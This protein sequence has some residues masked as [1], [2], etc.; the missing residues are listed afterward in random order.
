MSSARLPGRSGWN[1]PRGD[2]EMDQRVVR[3]SAGWRKPRPGHGLV[4]QI[5]SGLGALAPAIGSGLAAE[6]PAT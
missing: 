3:R 5:P 4:A 1:R 6:R 2:N